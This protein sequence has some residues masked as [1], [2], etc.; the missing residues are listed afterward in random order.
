MPTSLEVVFSGSAFDLILPRFDLDL[1]ECMACSDNV[2]RA[3]L[4]PKAKDVATLCAMLTYHSMKKANVLLKPTTL[5]SPGCTTTH[6]RP[7]ISE[8]AVSCVVLEPGSRHDLQLLSH[9]A[10]GILTEG[11]VRLNGLETSMGNAIAIC[12][13]ASVLVQNGR[14]KS[15]IYFASINENQ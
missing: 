8:F 2:V 5:T 13:S 7:P 3:G 4:T 14:H 15:V 10:I 1:M 6:Y 11:C 12:N 9:P